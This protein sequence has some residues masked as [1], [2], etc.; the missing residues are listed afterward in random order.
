MSRIEVLV[1]GFGGQGVVRIGQTI[2][3]A[4]VLSGLNTTMLVSHGT[5][6]RGGYVRTQVVLSDETVDSPVVEN[7]DIFCAMSKAAYLKFYHMVGENGVILYD[8]A[9][10]EPDLST[11]RKHIP[12]SVRDKCKSEFGTELYANMIM[13]GYVVA[14]LNGRIDKEKA[15][16]ALKQRIPRAIEENIRAFEMGYRMR[17]EDIT[18]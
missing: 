4:A 12:V 6:T 16:E 5:E 9:Y 17:N 8:P 15:I 2:G 3:L 10:V 13:Y 1:S 18:K 11:G 7:P 14:A